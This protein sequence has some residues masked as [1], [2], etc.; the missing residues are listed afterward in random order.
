MKARVIGR[1]KMKSR[2]KARVTCPM[3]GCSEVAIQGNLC[4]ACR[5]W[6][7]RVQLKTGKELAHYLY[8]LGRF[9]GRAHYV[10]GRAT[11]PRRG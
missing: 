1:I 4:P 10:P 9:A 5:S 7:S 8:R 3:E 11:I 6:W 2:K